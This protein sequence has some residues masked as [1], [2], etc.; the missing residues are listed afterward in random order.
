MSTAATA[1]G[2]YRGH[3]PERAAEAQVLSDVGVAQRQAEQALQIYFVHFLDRPVEMASASYAWI[4]SLPLPT[5]VDGGRS[6]RDAHGCG[7]CV[8]VLL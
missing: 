6:L 8:P 7:V 2:A 4:A 1:L 3:Y 5:V